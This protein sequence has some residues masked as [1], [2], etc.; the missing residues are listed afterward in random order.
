MT[1][2]N[3]YGKIT[4][5]GVAR[6]RQ[7]IGV[8]Q[9]SA[10]VPHNLEVTRDSIRHF[11]DGYGD[12]NPLFRDP[13]YAKKTRWGGFIAPPN[14]MYTLGEN[15][16]PEPNA[17]TKA[18][19]KGDPL[20]GTGQYQAELTFE[21]WRP[22]RIGDHAYQRSALVG[23]KEKTG[24]FGG[25]N[26][27]MIRGMVQRNQHGEP[28]NV[29][30]GTWIVNERD[31]S[32]ERSEKK[33]QAVPEPYTDE[34]LAEIDAVYEAEVRRGG[35]PRYWEDVQVGEEMPQKVKGPL[36]LTDIL[37]WH[38]GWGMQLSPPGALRLSYLDRKRRPGLYTPGR[39]GEWDTVQRCHWQDDWAI[40]LGLPQAYDYGAMRE[41]WLTHLLT[42]WAGDDGWLWKLTC[43]HRRFNLHGDT[44]WLRGRVTDKKKAGG[45]YEVNLDVWCENQRGEVAT[46]GTAVV[47]LPSRE[48][49]EVKLPDPPA[50]DLSTLIQREVERLAA[51][52]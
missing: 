42:D 8:E 46:P 18:L 48:G 39:F 38:I 45:R 50:N 37:L 25:R 28:M 13:D 1:T 33:P 12:D 32:K 30:R 16:T 41:T 19:L 49:G 14:Y 29:R 3:T 24:S 11:C 23:V 21:W 26:V 20:R 6:L 22:F 35:E 44:Q 4:D 10:A 31:T 17:E 52:R 43:Q 27:H 40:R 9:Y 47:L 7:R 15:D 34:Q 5:E 36:R 2:D 51:E